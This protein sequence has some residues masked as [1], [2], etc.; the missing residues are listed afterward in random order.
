MKNNVNNV[1]CK[2][3]RYTYW[4][5]MKSFHC[6]VSK[7]ACDKNSISRTSHSILA[8][9]DKQAVVMADNCLSVFHNIITVT[10]LLTSNNLS[11]LSRTKV[12]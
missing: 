9:M 2:L 8:C 4:Y 12:H 5:L 7:F 3:N 1:N 10:G 11:L 6:N